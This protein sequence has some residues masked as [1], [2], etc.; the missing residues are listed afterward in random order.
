MK[1]KLSLTSIEV[2]S[3][4][5]K[6]DDKNKET[7]VGGESQFWCSW[8]LSGCVLSLLCGEAPP[9]VATPTEPASKLNPE[10]CRGQMEQSRQYVAIGQR[11]PFPAYQAQ[12]GEPKK[13]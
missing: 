2:K 9:G 12:P 3:F 4:V 5:T 11:C 8:Y 1:K 10:I 7:I 6:L 13:I